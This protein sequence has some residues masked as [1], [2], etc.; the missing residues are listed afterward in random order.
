MRSLISLL[1][2]VAAAVASYLGRLPL[3]LAAGALI[4][5]VALWWI[6]PAVRRRRNYA[7]MS[8][9][10]EAAEEDL[11]SVGILSITA[12]EPA[13]PDRQFEPSA[14]G[15]P[16][17][18]AAHAG[19]LTDIDEEDGS[20]QAPMNSSG[21]A[22]GT[23]PDPYNIDVLA[24]VLEGFRALL[25]AHAVCV[26][27]QDSG[28]CHIIGTAGPNFA[29]Q[30]GESFAYDEPLMTS[31]RK[32][33]IRVVRGDLPARSLGYSRAPGSVLR[34]AVAPVG[35]T[36]LILLADTM[37]ENGLSHSRHRDLFEQ[38]AHLLGAVFYKDDPTRPRHKIIA[39]EMDQARACSQPLALGL[40]LLRNAEHVSRLGDSV[41]AQAED[42]LRERLQAASAS[43]RVVK[44]GEIMFGVFTDGH[45]SKVEEWGKRAHA[46]VAE[47]DGLLS[48]GIVI[49]VAI[50]SDQHATAHDLREEAKAALVAAYQNSVGAVISEPAT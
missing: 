4:L 19:S 3:Q 46:S 7:K 49:G 10:T 35:A 39:E 41:I 1:A 44:F 12:E 27:R 33:A 17:L 50:M 29:K 20:E 2:V 9:A 16:P 8:A 13:Q 18:E 32:F 48:G 21:D 6:V 47:A 22:Y 34:V 37:R 43:S 24:P 5:A 45:R 42:Q 25:A 36:P 28:H 38:C 23:L 40:V 31:P 30:P 14:A 15:P 26:L 11:E